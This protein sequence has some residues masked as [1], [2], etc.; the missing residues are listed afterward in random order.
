M[1]IAENIIR[2]PTSHD[3]AAPIIAGPN[4]KRQL[5]HSFKSFDPSCRAGPSLKLR[6]RQ[7]FISLL[8]FCIV[9]N[10]G[11]GTRLMELFTV[12]LLGF[13]SNPSDIEERIY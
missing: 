11:Q 12:R 7:Y 6:P 4:L 1:R 2:D 10:H 8:L 9:N 5:R 13:D 3:I